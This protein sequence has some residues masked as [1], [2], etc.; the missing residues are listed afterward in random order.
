MQQAVT[1]RPP[2]VKALYVSQPQPVGVT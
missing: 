1:V 2:A